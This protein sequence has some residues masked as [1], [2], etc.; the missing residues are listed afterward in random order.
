MSERSSLRRGMGFAATSFVANAF[1]QLLSS[2]LTARL[3]GVETIGEY[4]LVTAPW[5]TLVLFSNVSEQM[6][7]VRELSVLPARD[8]RVGRYFFPVLALSTGLTVSV[9]TIITVLSVAALRGPID[10]PDLVAPAIA[11]LVGYVVLEN[12][13][14]NLDSVFSAFRAGKEL[15][16]VRLT[17]VVSFLV[18][19][20]GFRSVSE[21]VWSLAIATLISFALAF[22]VRLALVRRFLT[23]VPRGEIRAGFGELPRLLKFSLQLVPGAIANGLSSQAATWILGSITNVRTVGA[24]SRAANVAMRIQEAG[25]RA[26][27]MVFPAMV[28]HAHAGND[29]GIRDDLRLSIRTWGLPLFLLVAVG[30][31]VAEG[32]L[33]VFGEGFD[34]AANAF[35][36][37]L[38]AYTLSVVSLLCGD[39]FLAQGRPTLATMLVVVR[40]AVMI[41]LMVPGAAWYGATG[42]AGALAAGFGVDVLVRLLIV[43]RT[44]F[45]GHLESIARTGIAILVGGGTAFALSRALDA[46]LDKPWGTI[47]GGLVGTAVYGAL[48]LAL[49][50]VSAEERAAARRRL[51]PGAAV[52]TPPPS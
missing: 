35:A 30:A 39:V 21:T 25:F 14:W 18:L 33:Q 52:P 36:L 42:A 22:V 32:A 20:V 7:L 12:V 31:G 2:V 45:G 1:V 48:V 44:V 3:Y 27:E 50:G 34:R 37:L 5:L 15:L 51:R 49:G 4:A 28:E 43:R 16:V 24:Y 38:L 17:Q 9:G 41:G 46:S 29:D 26:S 23:W 11:V 10:E 40:S 47:L 19:A 8:A 6:A 13:S